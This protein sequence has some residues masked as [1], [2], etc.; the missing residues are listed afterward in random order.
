MSALPAQEPEG[1][2]VVQAEKRMTIDGDLSDWGMIPE[3]AV[4]YAAEGQVL[5]SSA[6]LTVVARFSFDSESFYAAL[7]VLDDQVEF[8]EMSRREGDGF[9]LTFVSL[10][11]A[12]ESSPTLIFGFS[13]FGGEPIAFINRPEEGGSA[14]ARDIQL[15]IKQNEA[16]KTV[17]YELALPWT[18]VPF[19]RPFFQS[20]LGI[21]LT[22]DDLDGGQ[23]TIVQLAPDPGYR[24]EN[25]VP[26][27]S[28]SAEFVVGPPRSLEFQSSLNA[29]H[30]YPRDERKF[31]LAVLSPA[32]QSG[33]QVRMF[34][35]T[36]LG[37]VQSKTPLSFAQGMNI[38]SFPVE[39]EKTPTG[40]YELSVGLI[41]EKGTLRYTDNRRFFLLDTQEFDAYDAKLAEIK[42]GET[43]AK[44]VIFRESLPTVEVRLKWVRDFMEK[45]P[46]FA[47]LAPVEQWEQ[48]IKNLFKQVDEAKPALFPSGRVSR[49]GYRSEADGTLRSYS[50]FVPDWYDEKIPLPLLVTLSGGA[51][52]VRR[53]MFGLTS[54]YFGPRVRKRAGDFFILAPEVDDPAGW[55]SGGSA[56]RVIESIA[57]L[58]KIYSVNLKAVV[59]DGFANGGYGALRLALQNPGTFRGV[60][61]R[62]G[63][64]VPPPHSGA[65]SIL[66]MLDRAKGLNILIV[67]GE[68]EKGA[69]LDE[70]RRVV[71]L[72][73]QAKA[74]VGFIEVR[75][76]GPEDF[77]RWD[78]IFGW[79]GTTF[80]DTA[81]DLKPPKKEKE[82]EKEEKR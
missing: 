41:D 65:E 24:P 5:P 55:Y 46:L 58:A 60:I 44:D 67:H 69:P 45:S 47:D 2:K 51:V 80:G 10:E 82:K 73:Q 54:S 32:A 31:S 52:E 38:L 7:N 49:L 56:E 3:V 36:P 12:G 42:K 39:L 26:K 18:Y 75:G 68:R 48:E 62:S 4:H 30:F 27:K 34:L 1:L 28:L 37:N 29:N 23:K 50:V 20:K 19:F 43:H 33:W 16:Q 25:P 9:Y 78:D 35:T 21:N 57:H 71:S 14:P 15:R 72:L 40:A 8:P 13:R 61:V 17:V 70:A 22:Y 76:Q 64:F 59:V 79:L 6:D 77:E 74:N 63:V 81:V 66:D 53:A 11:K